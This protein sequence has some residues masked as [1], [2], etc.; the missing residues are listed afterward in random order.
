MYIFTSNNWKIVDFGPNLGLLPGVPLELGSLI[1]H[2]FVKAKAVSTKALIDLVMA[3][4]PLVIHIE[5]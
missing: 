5:K 2:Y 3:C 1:N 4:R